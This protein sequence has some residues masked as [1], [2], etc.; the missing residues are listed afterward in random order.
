MQ[1]REQLFK[2]E[3]VALGPLEH[4]APDRLGQIVETEPIQEALR[5]RLGQ[6]LEPDRDGVAPATP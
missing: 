4:A 2:E 3:R 6:R 1:A 5:L